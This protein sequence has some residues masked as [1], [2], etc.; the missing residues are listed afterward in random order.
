M[1]GKLFGIG[2]GP[3]DPGLMTIKAVE[4]L[5][6][7]AHVFAPIPRPD[8]DSVAYR[9]AKHFIPEQKPVSFLLFP[10]LPDKGQLNEQLLKNFQSIEKKLRDGADCAFITLGDPTIYSTF[11]VMQQY[12]ARYAPDIA[13]DIIPGITSFS[14]AAAQAGVALAEGDEILSIASGNDSVERIGEIIDKSDTAV[15]LKTYRHRDQVL[16]IIR[17]K[18]LSRHCIYVQKC[19]MDGENILFDVETLSGCPEYL[20]LLIV[21]KSRAKRDTK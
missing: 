14:F 19:G 10:M 1:A 9:I 6:A 21:K 3:G 5:N 8:G 11:T 18:G 13:I 7:V 15:L 12:F 20:S 17:G 2:V 4:I 16:D